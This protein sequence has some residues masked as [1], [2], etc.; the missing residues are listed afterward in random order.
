MNDLNLIQE[1]P[2]DSEIMVGLNDQAEPSIT[3]EVMKFYTDRATDMKINIDQLGAE[4]SLRQDKMRLIND[5]ITEINLLTD[6]KHGVDFS[7]NVELQ[8]KFR[9]AQQLGV[10][11]NADKTKF[12][13]VERDRLIENLHLTGDSWDKEN[14]SQTQKM[15]IYIKELDRVMMLLKEVQKNE[16]QAKRG[17]TAGI[18][19]G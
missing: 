8:E 2:V 19:G 7:Q 16:N 18:K 15:E 13:S 4:T 3:S 14:K 11:I 5:L 9:V 10:K 17:A 6:E 12:S 1:V